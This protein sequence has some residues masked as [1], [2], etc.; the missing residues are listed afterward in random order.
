[1]ALDLGAFSYLDLNGDRWF[2]YSAFCGVKVE[3]A[4]IS[5]NNTRNAS[6][7]SVPVRVFYA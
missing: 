7:L 4:I 1:M 6:D 5:G 3:M 2:S